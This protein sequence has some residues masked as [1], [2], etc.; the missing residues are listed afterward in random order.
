MRRGFKKVGPN[1]EV[2]HAF[3]RLCFESLVVFY[4]QIHS[5]YSPY[6]FKISIHIFKISTVKLKHAGTKE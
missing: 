3:L 6:K 4:G 2:V 5:P 1:A